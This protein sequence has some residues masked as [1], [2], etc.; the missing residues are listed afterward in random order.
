MKV[1]IIVVLV[2]LILCAALS[3]VWQYVKVDTL[4]AIIAFLPYLIV[5]IVFFATGRIKENRVARIALN[6]SYVVVLA[7]GIKSLI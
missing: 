1:R 4:E 2:T 5:S 6:L 7:V 3:F